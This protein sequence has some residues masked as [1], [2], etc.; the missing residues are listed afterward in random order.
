[1]RRALVT[2]ALVSVIEFAV[3]FAV[4]LVAFDVGGGSVAGLAAAAQLAPSILVPLV[5]RFIDRRHVAPMRFALI[6]IFGGLVGGA[7]SVASGSLGLLIGFAA[8]RALG[9]SLARPIHLAVVPVHAEDTADVTAAMVVTGWI[10]AI[11]AMLGPALTGVI[12]GWLEPQAVFLAMAVLSL[13]GLALSPRTGE[14]VGTGPDRVRRSVFK[15]RGA[16]AML[17]YKTS[18]S[19][20]SGAT[21]VVVVL[22]AIELLGLGDDG[23]GYLAS[24][25]GVGELIG[26]LLLVSL[27]G[28]ARL[29]GAL[30]VAALGRGGFISVLGLIPQAFL[31]LAFAGVFRPA[32]RVVQRLLLQRITPPDRYLRMYGVTEA[33][34][35]GGQALGAALVPLLVLLFGVQPAIVITGGLL[36]LTFVL[37][38]RAFRDID[39]RAVIPQAAIGTLR[40]APALEGVP[41]DALEYLARAGVE[42]ALEPGEHLITQGDEVVDAAWVVIDGQIDV[43]IDGAPVARLQRHD[44]AGEIALVH[45]QPRTADV[46]A[47]APSRLLRIDH[48]PFLDVVLSGRGGGDHVRVLAARRIDENNRR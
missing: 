9:Y 10:D 35:S 17:A 43:V 22:V 45:P 8:F 15:V 26:A 40:G 29:R 4:I 33:F 5:I 39:T 27:L 32:H 46:V 13:V 31:L 25:I 36:P 28:R 14:V 30:G 11:G 3:Y 41:A 12:L 19:A 42:V 47:S 18:A 44:L 6:W 34:D 16:K 23:A 38:N 1:M 48:E 2:Y 7:V 20:L 24:L 21:D 37:L